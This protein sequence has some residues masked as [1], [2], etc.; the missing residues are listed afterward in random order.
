MKPE[1]DKE[2]ALAAVD[3]IREMIGVHAP[4]PWMQTKFWYAVLDIVYYLIVK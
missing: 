4:A 1:T 2:A 3:T